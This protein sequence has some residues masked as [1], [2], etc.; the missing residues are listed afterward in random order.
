MNCSVHMCS[1]VLPALSLLLFVATMYDVTLH[2]FIDLHCILPCHVLHPPPPPPPSLSLPLHLPPSPS[3]SISF[4]LHLP[5]SHSPSP[6]PSISLP[7]PPPLPLMQ[8]GTYI[9]CKEVVVEETIRA[10]VIKPNQAIKLRA[11]KETLVWGLS[12]L[13]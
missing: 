11:R 5:P 4:P 3:P 2:V 7:P 13:D 12:T 1:A 8:S 9:P 6:S 10:T